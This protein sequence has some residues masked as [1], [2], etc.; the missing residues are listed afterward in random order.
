MQLQRPAF[1]VLLAVTA[2]SWILG[3]PSLVLIALSGLQ[4]A[5]ISHAGIG[6]SCY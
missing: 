4:F 2:R 3:I 1:S 6:E 5:F